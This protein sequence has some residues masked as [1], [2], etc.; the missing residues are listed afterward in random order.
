MGY[1][2]PNHYQYNGLES[3]VAFYGLNKENYNEKVDSFSS[4]PDSTYLR[5]CFC[6]T[7][8]YQ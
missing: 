5:F 8:F 6:C 2:L 7:H 1:T 4:D 3:T